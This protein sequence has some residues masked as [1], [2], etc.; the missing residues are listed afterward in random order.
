MKF[1]ST[2]DAS[3]AGTFEEAVCSGYAPDGGLWVPETLPKLT[4]TMLQEWASLD[5]PSLAKCLLRLFITTEEVPDDVLHDICVK[6][7]QGFADP[8]RPIPVVPVGNVF[9]SELFWGPT[10]CF[11]DLGMRVVIHLL[12]YFC[13]KRDRRLA[14]VVSTSGDTGPAAVQAVA[15][16]NNP[17]LTILYVPLRLQCQLLASC[18]CVVRSAYPTLCVSTLMT[19]GSLQSVTYVHMPQL[20]LSSSA[21][22]SVHYPQDQIS[23][24]QRRQMTTVDSPVVKVATFQGGGD[25][26]DQPIKNMQAGQD[27]GGKVLVTGVNSYNIGR[28]MTQMV[29]FVWTYLRVIEATGKSID[30]DTLVDI[31][32]PTGA[33]GNITG[34]YMTKKMG[35]PLGFLASGVNVNDMTFR[36]VT[37][38]KFHRSES[39]LKTLSDAIN[40]QVPYNFERLLFYLTDQNHER[41]QAWYKELEESK[42]GFTLDQ[43]TLTLLQKDFQSERVTDEEMCS[44]MREVLDKLNYLADPHTAVA[45]CCAKKLG[46]LSIMDDKS[47]PD[48]GAAAAATG[49]KNPVAILATASPCKFEESVVAALGQSGWETYTTGPSY[50]EAARVYLAKDEIDPFVYEA[51]AGKTLEENQVEWEAKARE[52]IKGLVSGS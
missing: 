3:I 6:S 8:K 19:R 32:L 7:Y 41:V 48:S 11:K 16:S 26:M 18:S 34:G 4:T 38:G 28:P 24:F 44:T 12:S 33:M 22:Y 37:T 5:Y 47:S 15:D 25:D 39:M 10:F 40:I 43:D 14:L 9:V 17:R 45:L 27:R 13:T 35:L 50:P 49:K 20:R 23:N 42:L 52:I 30:G 51:K 36:V 21:L 31:V 29:H 46:Y 2:R 1:L